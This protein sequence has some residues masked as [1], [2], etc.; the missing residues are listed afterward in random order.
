M[1]QPFIGLQPVFSASADFIAGFGPIH[2]IPVDAPFGALTK[3]LY[4]PCMIR[5]KL[6]P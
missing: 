1:P 3:K 6:R 4:H 5:V 2:R